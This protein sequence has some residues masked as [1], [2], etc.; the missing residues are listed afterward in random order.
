MLVDFTYTSTVTSST[1]EEIENDYVNDTTTITYTKPIFTRAT[2][3]LKEK[4]R[5]GIPSRFREF[6]I[7]YLA[8]P[9]ARRVNRE[10]RHPP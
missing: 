2:E 3:Q 9:L 1:Y 10:S 7:Y 8:D 5:P 6:T 4:K